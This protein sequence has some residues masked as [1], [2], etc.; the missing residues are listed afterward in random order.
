MEKK[1]KDELV[2][3]IV[4]SV[5]GTLLG[6]AATG[7]ALYTVGK[8]MVEQVKK[9]KEKE[10]KEKNIIDERISILAEAVERIRQ[11]REELINKE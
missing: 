4:M 5:I 6:V 7:F 11:A 10:Q 9:A 2:A 1:E 8:E 3:E